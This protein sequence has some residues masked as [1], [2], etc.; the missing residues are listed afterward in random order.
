[1][2][3]WYSM[4]LCLTLSIKRRIEGKCSSELG[5]ESRPP[6][7]SGRQNI[8][9]PRLFSTFLL[10]VW[11]AS[12]DMNMV[13]LLIFSSRVFKLQSYDDFAPVCVTKNRM[14]FRV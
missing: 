14:Q 1:M 5:L 7:P 3:K 8:G 4:P 11:V 2:V 13:D 9:Q 12:R 6:L 10:K